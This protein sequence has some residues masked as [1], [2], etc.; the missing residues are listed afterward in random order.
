MPP[1]RTLLG[2]ALALGL[3]AVSIHAEAGAESDRERLIELIAQLEQLAEQPALGQS[4]PVALEAGAEARAALEAGR[5]HEALEAI[6]VPLEWGRAFVYRAEQSEVTDLVAF[7]SHWKSRA[8]LP[9]EAS[10]L[11]ESGACDRAP[12][13]VRSVVERSL[14][15]SLRYYPAANAMAG[16]STADNGLFYLGRAVAQLQLAD[17]CSIE[18]GDSR[19]PPPQLRVPAAEAVR[20]DR[21]IATAY[22]RPGAAI[23]LHKK[24]IGLNASAKELR[25]LNEA[26]LIFGAL[27]AY[28]DVTRQLAELDAETPA[29]GAALRREAAE[30]ALGLKR[31]ALDHGI[32]LAFLEPA[33][34]TLATDQPEPAD[35]TSARVVV[36]QVIPAYLA[37]IE[38]ETP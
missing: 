3:L 8:D 1:L 16:A 11:M 14:N 29:D 24:F 18:S 12:A 35:L 6:I 27:H 28:L 7:E 22:E 19:L 31:E 9:A 23:E 36:E 37:F 32:A 4:G 38:T 17:L 34:A 13:H 10:R 2:S 33:I 30:I 25:E 26:G 20:L 5:P 21:E 15:R